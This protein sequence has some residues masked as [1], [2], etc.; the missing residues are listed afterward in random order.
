MKEKKQ[1]QLILYQYLQRATIYPNRALETFDSL[2][3]ID[4]NTIYKRNK[5]SVFVYLLVSHLNRK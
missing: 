5:V 2:V 1:K 4:T 3:A